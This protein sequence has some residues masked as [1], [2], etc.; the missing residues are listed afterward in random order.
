MALVER[1]AATIMTVTEDVLV[2]HGAAEALVQ[3]FC[4]KLYSISRLWSCT[5]IST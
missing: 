2:P 5:I 1:H 3:K 4:L